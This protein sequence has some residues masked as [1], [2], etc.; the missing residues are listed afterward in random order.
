MPSKKSNK[1]IYDKIIRIYEQEIID[2]IVK[3]GENKRRT[4]MESHILAY[5]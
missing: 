1:I 2:F 3:S 5:I 4:D